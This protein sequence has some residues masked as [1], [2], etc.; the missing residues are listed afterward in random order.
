M[1]P[2][3]HL[4]KHAMEH[5]IIQS[6]LCLKGQVTLDSSLYTVLLKLLVSSCHTA[7]NTTSMIVC[8]V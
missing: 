8:I 5:V 4:L 1:H 6:F 3:L 2:W 7:C